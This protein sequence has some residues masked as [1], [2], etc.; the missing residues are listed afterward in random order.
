MPGPF[1]SPALSLKHSSGVS[2]TKSRVL[3]LGWERLFAANHFLSGF[4]ICFGV[5]QSHYSKLPEFQKDTAN[6]PLI[7]TLAQAL[8]YLG[9][10]FSAALTK[11]FPKRQRQ[12]IWIGWPL[13]IFGLLGASFT[14][15]V[16]GL[17]GTQGLLYGLGFVTLT[18]PIVSMLNEWFVVRKGMALGLISASSGITGAFVPFIL[19][20]LL[21]KYGYRTTLRACAVGMAILTGPLIPL[22]KGRLP[23]SE[24]A[25]LAKADWGF[26]KKQRFWVY[27]LSILVQGLG[28][29]Y[30]SVFLPS[31]A[32]S[33]NISSMKAALLLA[34]MCIAQI[35]GQAAFGYISDKRLSVSFLATA[36]CIAAAAATLI[37]WGLA[38]SLAFLV[39][40]SLLYGFFGYGFSTMRVAMGREISD[41]PS[42]IFSLYAI[43]V[44]L[45]GVGNILVSPISAALIFRQTEPSHFAAGK[46]E[47]IVILTGTSSFLAALII[48]G[49]HSY[50]FLIH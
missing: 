6:I 41:D 22:F 21:D 17:I 28:F 36:C 31:Y 47:G 16:N 27:G 11:K 39:V 26:F 12:Q 25:S 49:W 15:S 4:P 44:F 33:I 34:L 48:G 19:Q 7:G 23:P 43:F 45:Q 5:F 46:Y 38:Q 2:L 24:H 1:L 9:A 3:S 50:K 10:P 20:E 14:S 32:T 18:Y 40:F 37:F 30:P 42:T 29:F 35:L 13:C 8:Y